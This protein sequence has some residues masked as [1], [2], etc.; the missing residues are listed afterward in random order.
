MNYT[1]RNGLVE[2]TWNWFNSE[3]CDVYGGRVKERK[4]PESPPPIRKSNPST[5]EYKTGGPA[6]I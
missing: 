4:I 3:L 5:P 2:R 1:T 6:T